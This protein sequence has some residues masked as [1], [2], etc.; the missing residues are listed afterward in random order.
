M[1]RVTDIPAMLRTFAD[2]ILTDQP[3]HWTTH[4]GAHPPG[5]FLFYVVLDRIGLGGG[6][7]GRRGDGARRGVG[8][9]RGGGGA[10][11]AGR[12]GGGPAGAAVRGAAARRGV[13][14]GVRGRDVR[15]R[16]GLGRRAAGGGRRRPRR[17]GGPGRGGRAA[18][19]WAARSTCPT[20]WCWAGCCRWPCWPRPGA[21]GRRV[22]GRG[23]RGRAVVGAFTAGGFW[24]FTGFERVR[25]IYAASIAA[26]RPVRPTSCGPTWRRCRSRS[27]RRST[28]GSA[29]RGR[30][31]R[32]ALPT[33]AALLARGGAGR[34]RRSPTCPGCPRPRWSGSGC[35]SRCGWC[36][37]CAL[38][39]RPRAVAGRPGGARAGGQ[40]PAAHRLVSRR[41]P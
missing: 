33:A 41:S 6:G 7:A 39:P 35:R 4:V 31:D 32:R 36:V 17:A 14:G 26:S 38:L 22:F 40:P 29:P 23:G 8:V 9:R 37:P 5:A 2:H 18:C 10:A 20:G 25:V 30:A 27:A 16:A 21:G 1:P 34:D 12:R 11:R 24:W 19:C 15:R 13:G 28:P 3:V